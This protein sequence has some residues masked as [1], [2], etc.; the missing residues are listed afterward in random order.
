MTAIFLPKDPFHWT[1]QEFSGPDARDF[2][3]R[4]TTVRA[5]E[6]EPGGGMQGFF[7]SATGKIRAQFFLSCLSQERFVFEYDAGKQGAWALALTEVVDQFTFGERQC[8]MPKS[9]QDCIWLFQDSEPPGRERLQDALVLDRG[10]LD[11]GIRWWSLWADSSVLKAWREQFLKNAPVWTSSEVA[12][13]RIQQI[14]PWIDEELTFDVNPLELG[15]YDAIA[16]NKGCYPG[17]E[18]VERVITQGAPARRL[19]RVEQAFEPLD[20]SGLPEVVGT[21]WQGN[22][23]LAII[24]KNLAVIGQ[25]LSI[26]GRCGV[27]VTGCAPNAPFVTH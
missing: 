15:L 12:L 2:L 20:L 8:L 27:T 13:R 3:H 23:G 11:F 19:V 4:L 1:L 10:S 21:S 25:K 14:R 7:L 26:S 6:L 5:R 9:S 16:E 18:V 22:Q 17:Q 24:R